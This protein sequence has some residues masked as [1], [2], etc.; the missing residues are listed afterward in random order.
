MRT[1]I[2]IVRAMQVACESTETTTVM[3]M[4]LGLGRQPMQPF[5]KKRNAGKG[6]Q[7]EAAQ[8][9]PIS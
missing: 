7:Q 5:A 2:N 1:V 6:D 8:K 4:M 9:S 3:V